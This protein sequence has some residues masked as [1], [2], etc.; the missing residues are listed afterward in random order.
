MLKKYLWK[1]PMVTLIPGKPNY[2]P[3]YSKGD[4]ELFNKLSIEQQNNE[5]AKNML[6]ELIDSNEESRYYDF[7]SDY[8]TYIKYVNLMCRAASIFFR[9]R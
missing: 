4:T 9:Y 3:D 1:K 7:T 8:S 6:A 2:L 5:D